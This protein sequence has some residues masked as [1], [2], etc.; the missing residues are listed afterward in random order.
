MG[1]K[2]Q[3]RNHLR[4]VGFLRDVPAIK[5]EQAA[6]FY[7]LFDGIV[8]YGPLK[9]FRLQ[10]SQWWTRFDIGPKLFGLY[11]KEVAE[12]LV[13]LSAT[14]S[15]FVDVGA[16]DG[17]FGVA[18]VSQGY[19]EKSYCFEIAEAG[20]HSIAE[21]AQLNDVFR[22]VTILGEASLAALRSIPQD[23]LVNAAIL[24]DIEGAEFDFLSDDVLALLGS[25][26][27]IIELHDWMLPDGEAKRAALFSRIAPHFDHK[28]FRVGLRDLSGFAELDKLPDSERWLLCDEGRGQSMEWV[29]LTPRS[30]R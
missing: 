15:V 7:D 28:V 24:I 3:I 22:H 2:K 26:H 8:A 12:L 11:E 13:S 5:A 14:R 10:K 16:A 25:C 19:Y 30:V 27:L 17:Y 20:R 4:N 29:S 6:H 23:E 9:G 1:L 21:T 18:A